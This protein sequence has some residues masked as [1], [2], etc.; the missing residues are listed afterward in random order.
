MEGRG[1]LLGFGSLALFF[2]SVR[3]EV[4]SALG[5][6]GSIFIVIHLASPTDVLK[7]VVACFSYSQYFKMYTWKLFCRLLK[8]DVK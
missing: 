7:H 1:Q 4:D 2:H 6:V 8:V 3:L 5:L